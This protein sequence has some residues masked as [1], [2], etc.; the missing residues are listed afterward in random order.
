MGRL[1]QQGQN[2]SDRLE[3]KIILLKEIIFRVLMAANFGAK[4]AGL[5][6]GREMCAKKDL[7]QN[8]K[9]SKYNRTNKVELLILS[10]VDSQ[11]ADRNRAA[12]SHQ[13]MQCYW[14]Y[15]CKCYWLEIIF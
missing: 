13:G 6:L 11:E 1:A 15:Y 2:L 8:A 5:R 12:M 10:F 3:P 14:C 7:R 9:L 4:Q